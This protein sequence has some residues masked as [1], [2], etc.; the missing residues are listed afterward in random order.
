MYSA[1]QFSLKRRIVG[2]GSWTLVGYMLSYALRLG[3]SLVMTRLLVPQMFGVM[4]VAMM[5]MTGLA[6]FTD[7]GLKQNIIQS[8]RGGEADYLNTAWTIQIVRAMLIWLL[9][10]LISGGL[11]EANHLGLTPDGSVYAD[12]RLPLVMAVISFSVII[13]GFNSTKFSEAS[14]RLSLGRITLIQIVAQIAGL[15]CMISWV[16]I[17]RSIWALV[18]GNIFATTVTMVLSH[19]WL[20]GVRNRWHWDH[21]AYSEIIHFGKWMFLSSI[22]GFFA[23]NS[24]RILLGG[25]IDSAAL[26]VYSIAFTIVS[27]IINV[28]NKIFGDVSFAAFSELARER[29]PDLKRSLYR[30][31]VF[32]AS[33]TYLC[34]GVLFVFGG[35]LIRLLYDPRY[36]QAG[37]ML[38]I[39]AVG[40]LSIPCHLAQFGLLARGLPKLFTYIVAIRAASTFVLV[41]LAFHFFGLH[42]ALWAIV[43][44]QMSNLPTT[45][46]Y[47]AKF[48]LFDLSKEL[49]LLPALVVGMILGAGL[50]VAIGY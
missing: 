12:P 24:D 49:L 19:Y 50:N 33:F 27:S 42:G 7:V 10:I 48:N 36:E 6:M 11:F 21:E 44:G 39:L 43:L 14:R 20:P 30:F 25:L 13:G 35:T 2:A 9:A 47:Q 18:A 26:G 32:T 45:I 17:D 46:Y 22:L 8:K 15:I 41:P 31:H 40:L 1:N 37:W 34:C 23:S 38:E 29:T 28:L 3:S 4:A 5:V 16:V